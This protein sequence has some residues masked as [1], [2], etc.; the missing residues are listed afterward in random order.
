[1]EKRLKSRNKEDNDIA[2]A[3]KSEMIYSRMIDFCKRKEFPLLIID[4]SNLTPEE[5][6]SRILKEL[7]VNA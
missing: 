2:K 4:T 3:K 1:M 6:V 5:V 7:S